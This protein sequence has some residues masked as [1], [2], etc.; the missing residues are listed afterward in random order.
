MNFKPDKNYEIL[1]KLRLISDGTP[2]GDQAAEST[3]NLMKKMEQRVECDNVKISDINIYSE[4]N[5]YNIPLRIYRPDICD[6]NSPVLIDIHGGGFVVGT[7]DKDDNRCIRYAQEVPCVVIQI[8]YRLATEVSFPSQIEDCYY[9]L[10]WIYD[11]AEELQIDKTRIALHGSSAGGNLCAGLSLYTRDKK[12]PKICFEILNYPC[13]SFG[14]PSP[15][16][17]LMFDSAPITN[18]AD[19]DAIMELYLGGYDG[20][21]P[22]YYAVPMNAPTL[23]GMPP[24]AIIACEYCPLRDDGIEFANRLMANGIPTELYLLPRVPHAFDLIDA[25]R[26]KWIIEGICMSLRREFC[27]DF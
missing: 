14:D 18:G 2:E 8:G 17:M 9:A 22:S 11:H 15:S 20:S 4:T 21:F 1:W 5:L 7:L 24:T 23:R 16:K 3:R 13:L 10:C 25:P 19:A 27:L 26:T 12:G 6:N